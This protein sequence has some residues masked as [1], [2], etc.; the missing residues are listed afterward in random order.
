MYGP[1][2]AVVATMALIPAALAADG[3]QAVIKYRLDSRISASAALWD[4]ASVDPESRTLF[5]G[6]IGGIMAVNLDSREVTPTLLVSEL[7]HGVVPIPN[8][9]LAAATN[10][11]ANAVSIFEVKT[12]RVVATIPAGKNP[13]AIVVEPKSGLIV[14]ANADSRDLTLIDAKERAAVATIKL[15]G[16]PEFMAVDGQGLLFS[17]IED[18]S[19]I[20]VMDMGNRKI[21]RRVRLAGCVS[22]TGLGYDAP[23]GLLISSCQNGVVKFIDSKTYRE[24]GSFKVG[25]GPDA[26]MV[27]SVRR[28]AFVPSGDSG[29]LTIFALR[30][31]TDITAQQTLVTQ[32]GTRTG[33]V[34]PRTGAVYLPA[35]KLKPPA[36]PD[37]WPSVVE[38]TFAILVVVP[39]SR[40]SSH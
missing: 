19:E 24:A 22:P 39:E 5:I 3:T 17:N 34:D 14:A 6:R 27:D 29:T 13:D 32:V 25:A 1:L 9:G 7:V 37:A 36:Q 8:T 28:L 38:G 31:A 11:S 4:Y 21:V 33:A 10:G 16:K 15:P 20:A 30:S 26:V 12:G 23:S 35:A 18:R 40:G 2:V